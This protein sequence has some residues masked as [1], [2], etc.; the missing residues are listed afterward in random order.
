MAELEVQHM[1]D[2]GVA[3]QL[4]DIEADHLITGRILAVIVDAVERD[5]KADEFHLQN[6]V[7][8]RWGIVDVRTHFTIFG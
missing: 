6:V 3:P 5:H 2:I 8:A 7:V 1:V 4:S